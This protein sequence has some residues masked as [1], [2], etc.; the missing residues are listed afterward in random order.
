MGADI[1]VRP[2]GPDDWEMVRDLRLA[3]LRDAPPA[4][5][6][7]YEGERDRAEV[8]WRAWLDRPTG[9]LV[10]ASMDGLPVGLAGG[11]IEDAGHVELVSMWVRPE[12]RGR[13]IGAALVMELARWARE[14]AAPA[15]R[16]WV[17]RDN[18]VAERLYSRQG[19]VRTGE[20]QRLP[21]GHPGI[22]EFAMRLD[23]R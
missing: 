15:I 7:T 6:S 12:A 2:A 1:S 8:A 18:E 19:F 17:T 23:L 16:L 13:G 9:T 4:F 22:D 20:T 21:A 11:Y 14:Q 3:A 10:V 5:E